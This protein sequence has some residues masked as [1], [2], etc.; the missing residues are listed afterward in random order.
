MNPTGLPLLPEVLI[1][2]QP[3]DHPSLALATPGVLR[4]I[5]QSAYGPMLIEVEDGVAYVNGQRVTVIE[6][7]Q[8]PR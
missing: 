3:A 7:L 2:P 8:M 6:E 5:W 1:G 4:C